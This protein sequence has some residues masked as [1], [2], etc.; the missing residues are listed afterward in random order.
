MS[1]GSLSPVIAVLLADTK[2][3][4]AKIDEAH[5]KYSQLYKSRQAAAEVLVAEIETLPTLTA[6]GV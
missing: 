5:K 3:Y 6:T 4:S 2:G 1:I